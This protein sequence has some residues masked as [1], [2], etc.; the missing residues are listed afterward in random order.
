MGSV[1]YLVFV[2]EFMKSLFCWGTDQGKENTVVCGNTDPGWLLKIIKV[3]KVFGD[4]SVFDCKN[5]TDR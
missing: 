3:G 5:S 2:E 4:Q 1:C